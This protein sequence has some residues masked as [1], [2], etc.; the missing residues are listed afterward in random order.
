[1]ATLF[2]PLLI[3]ILRAMQDVKAQDKTSDRV[4]PCDWSGCGENGQ[5]RAPKSRD[6]LGDYYWFCLHHVRQYNAEWDY[7]AGEDAETIE[8]YRRASMIG[9]RPTWRVGPGIAGPE[10]N[11]EDILDLMNIH[12]GIRNPFEGADRRTARQSL[13]PK[14]RQALE[15]LGLDET[16]SGDDIK[17]QFKTLVKRYHPDTNG[18]RR[19]ERRLREVIQAYSDL[20]ES[21]RFTEEAR[22]E[23][24]GL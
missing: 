17:R 7:F 16:A 18:G 1:M 3:P 24:S 10:W 8:R 19:T 6:A 13:S 21:G 2:L 9:H 23:N 15:K 5:Y 4:R 11:V 20:K 14:E 22:Q 12:P